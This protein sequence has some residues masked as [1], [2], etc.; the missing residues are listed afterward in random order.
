M[1]RLQS[2]SLGKLTA[3]CTL[4][5][6]GAVAATS[7]QQMFSSGPLNTQNRRNVTRGGVGSHAEIGSNCAAC[8]AS[9]WSGETMAS[10][11]LTCHDDIRDDITQGVRM[12]G[13]LAKGEDCTS[14][15]TEHKGPKAALTSF[16]QFHHDCTAFQLDGKHQTLDCK[17][18][19]VNELHRDTPKS[20]VSCHA[21]ADKHKGRLGANCAQCH[22]TNTWATHAI[23]AKTFNHDL[24]SFKLTGKHA[25]TDCQA[26]HKNE[27]FQ[28]TPQSCVACHAQADVHKGRFGANCA[29]CHTTDTWKAHN[30]SLATAFDHN[31]T[32]FK[33]TGK[34]ATVECKMCH[35]NEVFVG[36][37]QTCVGCHAEPKSHAK[38]YGSNCTMC[39]TTSTWHGFVF[40]HSFPVDHRGA[41]RTGKSCNLCHES[42][43]NF[44]S[45]TCYGCHHH[46]PQKEALRHANRKMKV[47]LNQCATCH[48]TGGGNRR[49]AQNDATP[50]DVCL[51]CPD[52]RF[53]HH[54]LNNG[55][56]GADHGTLP[57]A[58]GA[59]PFTGLIARSTPEKKTSQPVFQID[60]GKREPLIDVRPR[61]AGDLLE[62][63]KLDRPGILRR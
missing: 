9:A 16:E 23:D 3:I 25:K 21:K 29:E 19:H 35:K 52:E 47:P 53:L 33:L 34:H 32:R 22:S 49:V 12:H 43:A 58:R 8:H 50:I 17:A 15:H 59:N 48:P 13:Q 26:C 18:C 57:F 4:L 20:C 36:T 60:N 62:I 40:H 56:P 54:G 42:T 55:C 45:Y 37:P 28:G 5:V 31:I 2:L 63:L 41:A 61:V 27:V 44:A 24:T 7:G 10:R 6:V 39:H 46:T 38:K 14:C 51:A 1:E 11:C 30:V